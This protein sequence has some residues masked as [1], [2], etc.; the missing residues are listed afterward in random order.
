[1][2]ENQAVT[3][4]CFGITEYACNFYSSTQ[5]SLPHL[6]DITGGIYGGINQGLEC[7]ISHKMSFL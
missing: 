2:K 1:M 7:E 5:T 4:Q 3:L 6:V